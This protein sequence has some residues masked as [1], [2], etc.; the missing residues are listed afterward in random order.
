MTIGLK[1]LLA[2][3]AIVA[4][5][6]AL[7]STGILATGE[8][9]G[10]PVPDLSAQSLGGR[11]PADAFGT[12]PVGVCSASFLVQGAAGEGPGGV[13]GKGG[14]IIGTLPVTAGSQLSLTAGSSPIGGMAGTSSM[15]QLNGGTGFYAG[16][17]GSAIQLNNHWVALAGGGGGA[18]SDF[19]ANGGDAGATGSAG[20]NGTSGAG[21][22][23]GSILINSGVIDAAGP[24]PT[25]GGGGGGIGAN[26]SAGTGNSGGGGA[27]NSSGSLT[28]TIISVNGT[29]PSVATGK[30]EVTYT[31][32]AT[33]SQPGSISE[34]G[35]TSTSRSISF[36]ASSTSGIAVSGYK[37]T[38]NGGSAQT[39]STAGTTT[40]TGTISGL[41][42]GTVY[43]LSVQPSYVVP[44]IQSEINRGQTVLGAARTYSL[45][46]PLSSAT[47][48]Y[49]TASDGVAVVTWNNP[50]DLNFSDTVVTAQP[51]G[52]TCTTTNT[53]CTFN[54]L[55]NGTNYTFSVVSRSINAGANSAAVTSNS[56]T[57]AGAP[58]S[59]SQ[60]QSVTSTGL[61]QTGMQFF[62]QLEAAVLF[63]LAG[64]GLILYPK[65]VRS[66]N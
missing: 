52:Q 8:A 3:G 63:L 4:S 62:P 5:T 28:G 60:S 20:G 65:I 7:N 55:T 58:Q 59:Q 53:N 19:S 11:Q 34:I 30:A 32:C 54:N 36:A 29:A 41:T 33:P 15:S 27:G 9:V 22:A 6:V 50:A 10:I 40:L 44:N 51:G 42:P 21:G 56:V 13:G 18:G 25:A 16:G 45:T 49:A 61:V 23:G 46:I 64:I 57:P 24:N 14:L 39:L 37:Y 17:A 43:S 31:S 48:V 35:Q 12:V 2:A 26:G 38:L 47:N 1:K 66:R